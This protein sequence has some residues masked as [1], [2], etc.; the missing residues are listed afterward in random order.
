MLNT[1][2]G[3]P[4]DSDWPGYYTHWTPVLVPDAREREP[5][6]VLG[7]EFNWLKGKP[8]RNGNYCTLSFFDISNNQRRLI[9]L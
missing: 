1:K 2:K 3:Q 5:E 7:A 6:G 4:T 9:C 8:T